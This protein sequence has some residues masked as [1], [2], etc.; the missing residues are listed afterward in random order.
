[1]SR[2]YGQ[3]CGLARALELL[4]GR[5]ALLVVRDLLSGAKRFTEL[6]EGL[7]GIPTNDLTARLRELVDAG[8]VLRRLQPRPCGGDVADPSAFG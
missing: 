8:V 1:M 4:G 6:Q 5:W 3:F 7:P 2:G